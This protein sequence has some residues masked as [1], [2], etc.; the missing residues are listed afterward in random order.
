MQGMC[1]WRQLVDKLAA[2]AQSYFDEQHG[3]HPEWQIVRIDEICQ[4]KG[5][6]RLPAGEELASEATDHPYIRVRDLNEARY[7]VYDPNMAHI[8]N[9]THNQ[10][11]RYIVDAGDVVISIVGTIGLIAIIDES[12]HGANLTENCDKLT[13]FKSVNPLWAFLYLNSG[14]GQ[15]SIREATVGAVQAKLPLKNIQALM[16]PIPPDNEGRAIDGVINPLF[17]SI[18]LN[19][20]EI[21][22]LQRT[23][24]TLLNNISSLGR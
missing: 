13:A 21:L 7:L 1:Q 20:K 3:Q 17:A 15:D 19:Q 24:V 9:E 22:L 8:T 18:C 2:T 5:G 11:R 23:K 10:I 16:I 14:I 6:K 4:V 12:L